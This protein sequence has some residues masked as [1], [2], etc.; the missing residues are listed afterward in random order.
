MLTRSENLAP[1]A[2]L[3][4]LAGT[5]Q[6]RRPR[7]WSVST[8]TRTPAGGSPSTSAWPLLCPVSNPGRS[9][10]GWPH[11]VP[12]TPTSVPH[13]R[14]SWWTEGAGPARR[15]AL[16]A[17]GYGSAALLRVAVRDDG[18]RLAVGA[19]HGAVDGLGLVA[20]AAAALGQ[21]LLT[22]A[23]GIGDRPARSGFVRSSL[24]RLGE[25]LV[26]PP[27]RFAG[28]G[29]DSPVEDL[30]ELT[31]PLVD[32]GTAHLAAAAARV[33]GDRG[34]DGSTAARHRR[35]AAIGLAAR[36][37]PSDGVPEAARAC[38]RRRGHVRRALAAVDPEPDFPATSARGVGPRV[39]HLLRRR[40]GATALLSNLGRDRR[41]ASTRSRCSPRA[42][43]REQSRSAWRPRAST[44][45]LSL[46]T[47]RAE[48][49]ADEHARLL[50][51]LAS[52]SSLSPPASVGVVGRVVPQQPGNR[53]QPEPQQDLQADVAQPPGQ[54]TH[55]PEPVGEA[56]PASVRTAPS[57]R[58]G[59][60]R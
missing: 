47:R 27:P 46:R 4:P 29:E 18:R 3:A 33:F 56:R 20:V 40:L 60:R 49:T 41:A 42:A 9:R 17:A 37:R 10:R 14:W 24:A 57:S 23:R 36:G 8:A 38:R 39:A 43:A 31:R 22:R 1:C 32:R 48:F 15:A 5:R 16:A 59:V 58:C 28:S 51:D 6:S 7:R 21:P 54:L 12:P 25:A 2:R 35:V 55:D 13:P 45:T 19:H 26:D 50:A 44:T 11:S 52:A 34:H 53:T 30:S